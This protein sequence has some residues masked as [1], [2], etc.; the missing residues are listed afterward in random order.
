MVV[1]G[2]GCA[3]V[4]GL[5]ADLVDDGAW[6][7]AR[8]PRDAARVAGGPPEL[9]GDLAE[10]GVGRDAVDPEAVDG[11]DRLHL[12][13]VELDDRVVQAVVARHH[14]A[15]R[16][17]I[18]RPLGGDLCAGTSA[19]GRREADQVAPVVVADGGERAERVPVDDDARAPAQRN[20]DVCPGGQRERRGQGQD[21]DRGDRRHHQ[22][23]AV[24]QR[25]L[26]SSAPTVRQTRPVYRRAAS[27]GPLRHGN[28]KPH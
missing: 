22:W 13:R 2:D 26:R 10:H 11:V 15:Q 18:R 9:A 21:H 24:D 23:P 1:D 6:L 12:L 3:R 4:T 19:V 8:P 28:M 7:V 20:R 5:T 27:N 14:R 16:A 17:A 25:Q